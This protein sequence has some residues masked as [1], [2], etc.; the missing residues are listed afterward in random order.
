MSGHM[1]PDGIIS[2]P[3]HK[4]VKTTA[5]RVAITIMREAKEEFR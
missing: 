3:V 2:N 5:A 1:K 4:E